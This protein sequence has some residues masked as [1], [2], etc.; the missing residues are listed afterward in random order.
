M[1]A[2]FRIT[3]YIE[4][5]VDHYHALNSGIE[6]LVEFGIGELDLLLP[7]FA[8]GDVPVDTE[9]KPFFLRNRLSWN[10]PPRE[11]RCRPFSGGLIQ[12]PNGHIF[13]A[14]LSFQGFW[15]QTRV[16]RAGIYA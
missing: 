6:Y 11:W 8:L 9:K 13:Y 7:S 5:L 15:R 3:E 14:V 4:V 1:T 16:V 12:V 2:R 10:P